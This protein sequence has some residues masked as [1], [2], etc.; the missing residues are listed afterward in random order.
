MFVARFGLRSGIFKA[1]RESWRPGTETAG[2]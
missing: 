2:A 1:G